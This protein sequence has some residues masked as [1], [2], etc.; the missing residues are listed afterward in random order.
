MPLGDSDTV[1]LSCRA[2]W[3]VVVGEERNIWEHLGT[4]DFRLSF[5]L[6]GKGASVR[7]GVD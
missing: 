1:Y 7:D 5:D 2:V 3:V 6:V 4:F